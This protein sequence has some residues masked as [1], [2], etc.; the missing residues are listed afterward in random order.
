MVGPAALPLAGGTDPTH[1]RRIR[2]TSKELDMTDTTKTGDKPVNPIENDGDHDRVVML[3]LNADGT[4]DQHNPEIIG[5][6]EFAVDAAKAQFAQQA[7]AAVDAEK[8]A[9]LGLGG[10]EDGDTSDAK[11]DKLKAEH[12]KVAASAEKRAESVVNALH[13]D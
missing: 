8:R 13:K 12:D 3:S 10:T 1:S 6:K 7:V 5:D 9:E 4:P 11:I 2:I